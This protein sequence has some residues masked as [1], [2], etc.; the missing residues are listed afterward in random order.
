MNLS[1]GSRYFD[2]SHV[3]DE[4]LRTFPRPWHKNV[5]IETLGEIDK[6]GRR[7]SQ[8]SIGSHSGTHIDAPS[9]FL[10][11]GTTIEKLNLNHFIGRGRVILMENVPKKKEVNLVRLKEELKHVKKFQGIFFNFGWGK[12]FES[13]EGYYNDQPWFNEDAANL[14]LNLSPKI[15]G[16]DLAMPDN[17]LEGFGCNIDSPIHKIF[18]EQGIPLLENAIFPEGFQGEVNYAAIPLN[19]SGLDGSPVRFVVWR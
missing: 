9:H 2:L 8:I 12:N 4:S 13:S 19:L 7:T 3:I 6:V 14:I 16:Y 17:P 5:Q 18:L 11:S 15:V 10:E 1:A